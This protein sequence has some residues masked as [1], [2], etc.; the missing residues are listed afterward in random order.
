MFHICVKWKSS[1]HPW[2]GFVLHLFTLNNASTLQHDGAP[3]HAAETVQTYC[4][5]S[6][7]AF[8]S[9]EMWPHSSPDL[10][11]M[12]FGIWS[13][14]EHRPCTV[15][16]PSVKVLKK[17]I[18]TIMGPNVCETARTIYAQ[19]T[20]RVSRVIRQKDGYIE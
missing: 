7:I 9:K 13:V 11:S 15:S 20:Q 14:L 6:F 5:R 16:H 18:N 4:K 19:V 8:W 1:I 10:Y 12:H 2:N 17:K 3:A